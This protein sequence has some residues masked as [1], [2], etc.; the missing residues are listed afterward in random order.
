MRVFI[1]MTA[2]SEYSTEP[3]AYTSG[4]NIWADAPACLPLK[5]IHTS[6]AV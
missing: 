1:I 4:E 6:M 5:Y 2:P 3:S